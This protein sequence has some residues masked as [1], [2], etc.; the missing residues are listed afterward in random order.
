MDCS[1]LREEF[2]E[3]NERVSLH[4][5]AWSRFND[6]ERICANPTISSYLVSTNNG[7]EKKRTRRSLRDFE[8]CG[9]GSDRVSGDGSEY[10]DQVWLI[11]SF[12]HNSFK[13][14][15][16]GLNLNLPV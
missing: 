13:R 9:R 5:P 12:R 7:L 14:S 16:F 11:C 3:F 8:V 6:M 2:F 4:R 10:R 1:V 15:E